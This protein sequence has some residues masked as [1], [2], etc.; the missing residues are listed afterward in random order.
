MTNPIYG[1]QNAVGG[2][3]QYLTA[4]RLPNPKNAMGESTFGIGRRMLNTLTAYD[5]L[6][7]LFADRDLLHDNTKVYPV[8]MLKRHV[9]MDSMRSLGVEYPEYGIVAYSGR[10]VLDR[11]VFQVD[12]KFY[13]H[14]D[15]EM[16]VKRV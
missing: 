1:T 10:M 3:I 16:L 14:P 2:A 4:V 13:P 15:F 6:E 12:G 11:P 9:M 8:E 7:A 5:S